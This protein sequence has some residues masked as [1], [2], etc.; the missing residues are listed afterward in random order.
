MLLIDRM[1][2]AQ[3]YFRLDLSLTLT[4]HSIPGPRRPYPCCLRGM[5]APARASSLQKLFKPSPYDACLRMAKGNFAHL[6]HSP[7]LLVDLCAQNTPN[8]PVDAIEKA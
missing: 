4:A 2:S 1:T 7:T 5:L 3:L 8:Q 6:N